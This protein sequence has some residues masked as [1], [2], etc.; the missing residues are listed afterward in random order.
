MKSIDRVGLGLFALYLVCYAGFVLLAAFRVDLMA[1]APWRGINLATLSGL[2]LI[3][4]AFL[5]SL[6]YG[7]CSMPNSGDRA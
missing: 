4:L 3:A 6:V 5:L 1:V 7:C 2:G